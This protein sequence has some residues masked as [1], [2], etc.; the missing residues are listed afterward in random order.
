MHLAA[1]TG[2]EAEARIARSAGLKAMA[3]GGRP[4]RTLAC[5]ETLLSDGA[6]ALISF[7]IAGALAPQ[8]ATGALLL[9]RV[10]VDE[11]GEHFGVDEI[12]RTRAA[13]KLA[14]A[15]FH[16]AD[17]NLLGAT[18]IA[19]TVQSKAALFRQTS[20]VAVDLES[21]L[22]A[23]AAMKAG[24]PFLV[25]RVIADPASRAVPRAAVN[26]LDENG[27]PA[28]GRVLLSVLRRPG[29]ILPLIRLA[30]DTRRALFAL[31]SALEAGPI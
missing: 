6:E 3:S 1:V 9:P 7:G 16:V 27:Q 10:V 17:G 28:L 15:G 19:A 8:L 25:L 2:L 30:G 14:R 22:V 31:R 20:A 5:A 13:S 26:G 29:Q 21:H 24:K 23:R 4:A 18:H 12:L 11:S